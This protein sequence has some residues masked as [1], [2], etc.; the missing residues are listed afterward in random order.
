VSFTMEDFNRQYIKEHFLQLT[1]QERKELLLA[2]PREELLAGLSPEERLAEDLIEARP[3]EVL[4]AN[5]GRA[6]ADAAWPAESW[7]ALTAA[8]V[9][10]WSVPRAFGGRELS[11]VDL[12]RG[13]EALARACLTAAFILSQREAAVRRIVGLSGPQQQKRLLPKLATGD[14]MMTVGLSQ[15]TTSRQHVSPSLTAT[16]VDGGRFRLDGVIPWVT[17]ADQA[18]EIVIGA[19]LPD[20]RQILALLPRGADGV[21]IDPPAPLMALLGSRTT[22]IHCDAVSIEPDQIV[23]GPAAQV[24][25]VGK[26]GVGGLETSCL[27]LGLASAA[28]R[29]LE[30]EAAARPDLADGAAR[31]AEAAR[32]LR[33]KLHRFAGSEPPSSDVMALRADCTLL[34][35]RATQT[36]MTTAKGA[37]FVAPHPAQRWAR[38]ALF[39]LVW[40]CPRPAAEGIL[41]RLLP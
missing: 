36:A 20:G 11:P 22:Q 31:F 10:A 5:A 38:Q 25:A 12:L 32:Q 14:Y 8:G 13:Y 3:L 41:A 15:L 34:A 35:L 39:F 4:T 29:F 9:P 1:P 33:A 28:I 18:D 2:L 21:A 30:H 24:A 40:S 6:D 16:P 17:A 7:R 27:A 37:G 23:A 26:G 19:T